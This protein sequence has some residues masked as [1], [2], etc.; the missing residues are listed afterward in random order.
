LRKAFAAP[1]QMALTNYLMHSVIGVAIFYGIGLGL[2]AR[3]PLAVMMAGAIVVF[4]VQIAIS[5]LWLIY[6]AFGP[7]EWL[8]RLFTYRR[9]VPLRRQIPPTL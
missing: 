9:R 5:R 6:A 2:W 3:V 4:G 8:W 7:A 1:G